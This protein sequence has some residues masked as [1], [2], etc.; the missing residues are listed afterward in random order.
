MTHRQ[1]I[2]ARQTQRLWELLA[3]LRPG[4]RF[5]AA[6]FAGL[7]LDRIELSQLPFTTKAELVA[8]QQEYP[9]FGSALTFPPERY[10]RTHQTSGTSTGRPLRWLDTAESWQNL[11]GCFDQIFAL[12]GLRRDDRLFFAFSF[13]PF[14][15]FWVAF[16]SAVR[17]GRC[18]LPAGGM[19]ST[20]RLRYMLEHSATVLF[21]TPSYALHLAE[22]AAAHGI[23]IARSPVRMIVVA[24]EPGGSIPATRQRIETAW[25]ARV[26]DHSG[27]TE[28]GPLAV[29]C[30]A[31]PG[32]L[33]VL[34]LDYIAEVIDPETDAPVAPGEAGELVL[35]NLGRTGSPLI[36]YRSGDLAK[37]D[38][39]PCRCG[40]PFARL[41]GGILGRADDMIHL[42]G[43]NV[44][45]SAIEA[46]V[47]RFPEV[48]EYRVEVDRSG[49]LANLRIEIECVP[50]ADG[51]VLVDR[52]GKA[53][54][55]ELLFRADVVAVPPGT[56]PRFEMKARRVVVKN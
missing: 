56:L 17:A 24:G 29:E 12:I 19:S 25:G 38:L 53:L 36:R 10:V 52:I 51:S 3:T 21:C 8:D 20:A 22:V 45:P 6:K 44:Y 26:I 46:V 4:N 54:G 13:G 40:S 2:V 42:R 35:T 18:V 30:E 28:V 7:D 47:R 14:L 11:L 1:P 55:D 5:Y 39:A 41:A 16:E 31:N 34:E 9:P 27:M 43:N 50:S 48:V 33:H 37:L 15:G 32:G 49:T 23:D